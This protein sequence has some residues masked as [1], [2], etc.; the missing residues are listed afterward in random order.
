[1]HDENTAVEN[2]EPSEPGK[3]Y[4]WYVENLST[5]PNSEIKDYEKIAHLAAEGLVCVIENGSPRLRI[6]SEEA[7]RGL[8]ERLV[9]LECV[10]STEN[11]LKGL[12]G[13]TLDEALRN[14]RRRNGLPDRSI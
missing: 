5:I 11:V 9:F 3:D 12:E 14:A 10:Y 8:V 2:P 13:K 6:F 1:M 4:M 7:Y